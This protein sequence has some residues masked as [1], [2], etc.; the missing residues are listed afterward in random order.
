[1]I[2]GSCDR[3]AWRRSLRLAGI[4]SILLERPIG[5]R[6][7]GISNCKAYLT[8]A[9]ASALM[10]IASLG[11]CKAQTQADLPGDRARPW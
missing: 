7:A 11:V 10:S 6:E 2:G 8:L 3:V 1:M 5:W 9:F 4:T